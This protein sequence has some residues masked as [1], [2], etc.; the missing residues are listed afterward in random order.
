MSEIE[1]IEKYDR[2]ADL[3]AGVLFLI[4][5]GV[6]FLVPTFL[7]GLKVGLA[8]LIFSLFWFVVCVDLDLT[9]IRGYYRKKLEKEWIKEGKK[10]PYSIW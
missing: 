7:W 10:L 8:C 3:L 4:G 2:K 5:E 9:T 6:I 1:T